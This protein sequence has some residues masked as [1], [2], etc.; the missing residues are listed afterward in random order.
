MWW[1][2]VRWQ[3]VSR[4]RWETMRPTELTEDFK[5]EFLKVRSRHGRPE[6]VP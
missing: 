4:V 5:D 2:I 3:F 6:C 1:K